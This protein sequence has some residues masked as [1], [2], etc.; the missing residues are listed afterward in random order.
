MYSKDRK[1][2]AILARHDS[3]R[4][5]AASWFTLWQEIA[6]YVMPRKSEITTD[7]TPG[8]EGY[9]DNLFNLTAVDANQVLAAGQKDYMVSGDWFE[10][11]SPLDDLDD[12]GKRWYRKVSELMA[13]ELAR[14][15]FHVMIHEMFLDRGAF[16]TASIN[17]EEGKRSLFNFR[18]L[19]VG[20]FVCSQ[21]D[22]G[23]VD[24]II[25]EFTLTARQC[26]SQFGMDYLTPKILTAVLSDDVKRMEQKFKIIHMIAPREDAERDMGKLD[27]ANKPIASIYISKDD[28]ETLRVSGYDEMPN[29]TT[30][31]LKWTDSPY[32]FSPSIAALPTIKQVNFIEQQMDALAEIAAFPRVLIPNGI[33]GEVDL[34]AG[35]QTVYDPSTSSNAK[36]EEWGT[37]GRYDIGK[38]RIEA[39]DEAIRRLYHN[40]LFHMLR[41]LEKGQMTAYEVSRREA[42]KV[43]DFSPTYYQLDGE[44]I[45]PIL[46]RAYAM[47]FRAGRLPEPPMS[48]LVVGPDGFSPVLPIPKVV[49][50]GKLS[51]SIDAAKNDSWMQFQG[52]MQGIWAV[53]PTIVTDN[54]DMDKI[55]RGAG[56]NAGMPVDWQRSAAERDEIR[57]ERA[58]AQQQAAA[59]EAAPGV[60]KAAKDVSEM[61]PKMREQMANV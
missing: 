14:S 26:L 40:D 53:D 20:T 38:D 22:E 34:R 36:P 28:K 42:E 15:N 3:M 13:D 10:M 46:A 43:A 1:A 30:R 27:G 4:T 37:S 47:M 12:E 58:Q 54:W 48:V 17:L 44:V 61:D 8:V 59:A 21:D 39:K 51:K 57:Q 25:R 60:A 23:Y 29:A 33:D 55:T 32:G 19:D 7:K 45:Q 6:N 41:D 56:E 52:L 35:G 24:T 31:F 49:L 2:E 9:T 16:G 50:T 5:E 11:K 18:K